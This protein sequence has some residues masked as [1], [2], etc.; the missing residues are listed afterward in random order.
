MVA[1]PPP[2]YIEKSRGKAGD[3]KDLSPVSYEV[4]DQHHDTSA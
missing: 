1:H 4:R 3:E 2:Q